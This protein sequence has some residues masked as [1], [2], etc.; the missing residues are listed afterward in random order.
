MF[1]LEGSAAPAI[2][3]TSKTLGRNRWSSEAVAL[4]A[5]TCTQGST[6]LAMLTLLTCFSQNRQWWSSTN[7]PQIPPSL[8]LLTAFSWLLSSRTWVTR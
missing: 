3:E 7:V 1:G 8:R 6:C 4:S 2:L 5:S